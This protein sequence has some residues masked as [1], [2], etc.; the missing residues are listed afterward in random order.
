MQIVFA[1][2]AFVRDGSW[3]WQPVA[4]LMRAATGVP[5]V[6][7]AMPSCG[8]A[9]TGGPLAGG[10][11]G[12]RE[13]AQALRAAL[14]HDESVVVAHSYGGTVAAEGAGHANV[15]HLVYISSFLPEIG[16]SHASL[17]PPSAD[18]LPLHPNPDG[19]VS[20]DAGDRDAVTRRFLHDVASP[21]LVEGAFSRLAPQSPLAFGTPTT[22]AAWQGAESTYLLCA[23][24]ANTPAGRQREHA[25]RATR[26]HTL[27]TGHHPFLSRPDLVAGHLTAI[28]G[29]A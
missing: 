27:P 14:D 5:S 13:D 23:E 16:Q 28:L 1:H 24:D 6:A 9:D 10:G 8:E 2:G 25:Q 3:W 4:D 11:A 29:R 17:V 7:V 12:L 15:A 19:T 20:L 22:A 26:V 21:A 18:P